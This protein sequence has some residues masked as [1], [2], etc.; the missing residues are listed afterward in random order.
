MMP[1]KLTRL[2]FLAALL[3][4]LAAADATLSVHA[5]FVRLAPPGATTTGVFMQIRNAGK[6][7]RALVKADCRCAKTVELHTHI[8]DNGVMKMRAIPAIDIRAGTQTDLK[9][10][11]FHVMLI[12]MSR[13]LKEGDTIALTLTFDDA[14]Q[15]TIDA[16]VRSIHTEAA[17][18]PASH[19]AHP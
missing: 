10:G 11:S 15:Q 4:S 1:R 8:N 13:E 2:A 17:K 12:D 18:L 16:P 7:D 5:P 3:P 14:S 6:S 19:G 9:P